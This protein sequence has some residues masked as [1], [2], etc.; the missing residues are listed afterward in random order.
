MKKTLSYSLFAL[1]ILPLIWGSTFAAGVCDNETMGF[2]VGLI[3]QLVKFF[4][5]GWVVLANLAGKLMTNEFIYGSFM[6]LDVYLWK[7][8]NLSKNIANFFLGFYFLYMILASFFNDKGATGVIGKV[9]DFLLAGIGIQ[10]SWFLLA[11]LIDLATIAAAAVGSLPGIIIDG[12]EG[13]QTTISQLTSNPTT[14]T[15][16]PFN[17]KSPQTS[18]PRTDAVTDNKAIYDSIMPSANSLAG[19][20]VFLG[21][22]IFKFQDFSFLSGDQ[23]ACGNISLVTIVNFVI[24][25]LFLLPLLILV[26]VNAM[27]IF[28]LWLFIAF[29]PLVIL[30][31]VFWFEKATWIKDFNLKEA[32]N[33]IFQPVIMIWAMSLILILVLSLF[34]LMWKTTGNASNN[35]IDLW[36]ASLSSNNGVSTFSIPNIST[37]TLDGEIFNTGYRTI[38]GFFGD[39][40]MYGFILILL[41]LLVGAITGTSE[42]TKKVAEGI[43][44]TAKWLAA[45]IPLIPI[46]GKGMNFRQLQNL[47]QEALDGYKTKYQGVTSQ[48]DQK[49]YDAIGIK[50][51][52]DL[53]KY[54]QKGVPWE[55]F[56]EGI[57]LSISNIVNNMS[58]IDVWAKNNK[59]WKDQEIANEIIKSKE[60][61]QK[62]SLIKE[63]LNKTTK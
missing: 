34:Q 10:V 17:E 62:I 1:L 16:D 51:P 4:S 56:K 36:S 7:L 57:D 40:F 13:L 49:L 37:I 60:E 32:I 52:S 35:I 5:R 55:K 20:L 61:K 45:S 53:E 6:N 58:Y 44:S 11:V 54:T 42:L 25:I 15:L 46:A 59:D 19:P 26:V 41:W 39:M 23:K 28:Y 48:Y 47:P 31:Y 24:L 29:S 9:K 12:N 21:A 22:S 33:L 30:V 3:A 43:S 63:E 38:G 50:K 2:M 8:W 27:R 14:Y 18:Q